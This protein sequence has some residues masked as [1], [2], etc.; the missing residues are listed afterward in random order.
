MMTIIFM[1][2]LIDLSGSG[3]MVFGCAC[4][5]VLKLYYMKHDS[6]LGVTSVDSWMNGKGLI[7]SKRSSK[8]VNACDGRLCIRRYGYCHRG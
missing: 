5:E 8:K 7:S 3:G 4:G 2:D 1:D 6:F